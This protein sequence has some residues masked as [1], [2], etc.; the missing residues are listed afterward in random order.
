MAG[1]WYAELDYGSI[2]GNMAPIIDGTINV[3]FNEDGSKTFT[4]DCVD[5]AGHKITGSVTTEPE[6]RTFAAKSKGEK[7]PYIQRP[8]MK[9]LAIR[10]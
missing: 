3:T 6:T 8:T 4:L 5:D 10:K 1:C 7:K 2:S 9:S